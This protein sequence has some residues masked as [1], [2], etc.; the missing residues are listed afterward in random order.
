MLRSSISGGKELGAMFNTLFTRLPQAR[1][2]VMTC[3]HR[4]R[5]FLS[6]LSFLRLLLSSSP[7][8]PPLAIIRLSAHLF[9]SS[10]PPASSYPQLSLNAPLSPLAIAP[11]CL[12]APLCTSAKKFST[13][14][15]PVSPPKIFIPLA[16]PLFS[17][18]ERG[19]MCIPL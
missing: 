5:D 6:I 11:S 7:F 17:H 9:S 13:G 4:S 1:I 16:Q 12:S 3:Y 10:F 2:S 14:G 18:G 8:F 15:L 19:R